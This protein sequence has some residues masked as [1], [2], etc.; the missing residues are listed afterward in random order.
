MAQSPDYSE[1]SHAELQNRLKLLDAK[2]ERM[3]GQMAKFES[4][5]R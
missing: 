1:W 2:I 5:S 3:E 4:P